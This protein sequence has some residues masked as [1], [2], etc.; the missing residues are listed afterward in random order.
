[1][2]S[3]TIKPMQTLLRYWLAS[4]AILS[5]LAG[6]AWHLRVLYQR[7]QRLVRLPVTEQ[8]NEQ[9][10]QAMAEAER[11]GEST[12]TYTVERLPLPLQPQQ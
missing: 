1:M 2:V 12:Y 3:A 4:L 11:K 6:T 7:H 10:H 8:I 5:L 9:R